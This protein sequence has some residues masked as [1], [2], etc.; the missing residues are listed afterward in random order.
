MTE[1]NED[2]RLFKASLRALLLTEKNGADEDLVERKYEDVVGVPLRPLVNQFGYDRI[3][4][5]EFVN[6]FSDVMMQ[7]YGRFYGIPL[8]VQKPIVSLINST[9][10]TYKK[11]TFNRSGPPRED[12][13]RSN[14]NSTN[15]YQPGMG[16]QKLMEF[17]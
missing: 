13:Y 5:K 4:D 6:D 11:K 10:N 2:L 12:G 7:C 16:E 14:Y 1:K 3:S 8:E 17:I 9:E 15:N